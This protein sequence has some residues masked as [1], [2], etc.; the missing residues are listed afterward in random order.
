MLQGFQRGRQHQIV[1]I[2]GDKRIVGGA[3]T[4]LHG[5]IQTGGC[6]AAARDA[7]EDHLRLV[8]VA[9]RDAIVMGEGIIDGG[10]TRIVFNQVA[11]V[12]AV[13]TV[14]HRRRVEVEL[15]LQRGHQRLHDILTKAF[16]LQ[17]N[18]AY[19]RDD[20]GVEH[21]RSNTGLLENRVYL[22]LHGARAADIFDKRQGYTAG[23]DRE[24]RHDRMTQNFRRNSGTVGNIKDVAI[25]STFHFDHPV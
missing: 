22:L 6:F 13:G 7:E 15:L 8:K 1:H 23:G 10:D 16:T 2:V 4:V 12:E 21:Q 9:Q 25:Y 3:N 24:L 14:G 19:F 11:G 5:E 17:N 18:V 20:D